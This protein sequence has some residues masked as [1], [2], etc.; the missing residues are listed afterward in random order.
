LEI[1]LN[2]DSACEFIC[3]LKCWTGYPR[4]LTHLTDSNTFAERVGGDYVNLDGCYADSSEMDKSGNLFQ[5]CL[6]ENMFATFIKKFFLKVT[7]NLEL[8]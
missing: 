2:I 8:F 6:K 4:I 3:L 7:L 5:I 1:T